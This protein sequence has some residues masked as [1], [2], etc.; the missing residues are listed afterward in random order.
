MAERS[1]EYASHA[2][3][4]TEQYIKGVAATNPADEI[5]KAKTLLDAGTITQEEY[6][7]LKARAL[8]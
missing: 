2:Q 3:A 1:Y 5:E 4:A 6:Q 8:R 7:G